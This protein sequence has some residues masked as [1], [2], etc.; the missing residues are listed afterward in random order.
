M[1]IT[2]ISTTEP[3]TMSPVSVF[4]PNFMKLKSFLDEFHLK[5]TKNI[6]TFQN[7]SLDNSIL[8]IKIFHKHD[9]YTML[10]STKFAKIYTMRYCGAQ[11]PGGTEFFQN[12]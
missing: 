6:K 12:L 4:I 7:L 10:G 1:K 2:L 9:F 8:V 11:P 3:L 5:V